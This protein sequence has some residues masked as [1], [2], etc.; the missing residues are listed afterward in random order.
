MKHLSWNKILWNQ[1]EKR[2]QRLQLRI[3]TASSQG[4]L[5]KVQFLQ[6]KLIQSLDAKL[7][8]VRKITVENLNKPLYI[9]ASK[10]VR[11]VKKLKIEA[12]PCNE[13]LFRARQELA[14][15]A[16]EPQ[17]E[18]LFES[19]SYGARPGRT[20]QDA[21]EAIFNAIRTNSKKSS[22][23]R[24]IFKMEACL[25]NL[26]IQAFIQKLNTISPIE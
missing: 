17:W 12:T 8:A 4:N 24:F 2:I 6:Y 23:E 13:L 1:V 10:K 16:L 3:Y 7:L 25:E 11:L 21:V 26:N 15:M 20:A 5:K 22:T 18:A 14:I 9:N 19:K